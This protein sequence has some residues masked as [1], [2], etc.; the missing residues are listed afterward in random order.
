MRGGVTL[1]LAFGLVALAAAPAWAQP[2]R[3]GGGGRGGAGSGWLSGLEAG[4]ARARKEGKP[5]FV[6]LRCE[7]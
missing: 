6:V 1:S 3:D 7:P 5:L 4:A 2:R